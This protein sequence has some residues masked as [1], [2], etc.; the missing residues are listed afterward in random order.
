[1]GLGAGQQDPGAAGH[2]LECVAVPQE[3][4][5]FSDIFRLQLQGFGF[6]TA[7]GFAPEWATALRYHEPGLPTT[8]SLHYLHYTPLNETN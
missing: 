4:L 5:Q 3:A 6:A 8:N 2:P 7:H 1:L